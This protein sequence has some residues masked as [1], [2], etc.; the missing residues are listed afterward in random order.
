MN[1]VSPAF[2]ERMTE[3]EPEMVDDEESAFDADDYDTGPEA[4]DDD[5]TDPHLRDDA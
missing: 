4:E 1:E 2:I 3:M 5:E